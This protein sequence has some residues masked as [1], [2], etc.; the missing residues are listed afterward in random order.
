[1]KAKALD[2]LQ[3]SNLVKKGYYLWNRFPYN[4]CKGT[5]IFGIYQRKPKVFILFMFGPIHRERL[6]HKRILPKRPECKSPSDH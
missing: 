5:T 6:H 2:N 3:I 4:F 1:M